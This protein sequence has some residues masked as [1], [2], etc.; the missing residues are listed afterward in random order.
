MRLRN[1]PVTLDGRLVLI[2]A[3][4]NADRDL[5]EL[6]AESQIGWCGINW[7]AAEKNED[8]NPLCLHVLD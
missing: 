1:V 8:L 5:G 2:K 3:Q 7:I 4:V 6:F